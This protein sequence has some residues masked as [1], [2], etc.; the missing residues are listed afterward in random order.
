MINDELKD[1]VIW[2]RANKLSLNINK[3][4]YM[5]FSNKNVAQPNITIEIDKQPITCV[6]KTK[7]LGVIIDSK[8]S[9][10]EHIS[11]VCG[12]VAKGIGIISKVR[13]YVNKSTLL[14]L[15]YSFIYPYLTYCNHV[16]GLSCKSYMDA[17]VKL[18]KRAIRI[19]AGVHPRTPILN[20][21]ANS[22]RRGLTL[23]CLKWQT[24]NMCNTKGPNYL[25]YMH[26]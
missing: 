2:L 12:K 16:W 17:L 10:K 1:M 5:L 7:F 23:L 15:Y 4:H 22:C 26:R 24:F 20:T 3:T 21:S 25:K 18:Q 19:I 14:E 8:L 13:K 6:T 11:Y 9:W